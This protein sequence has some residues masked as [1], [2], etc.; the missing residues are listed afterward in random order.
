VTRSLIPH[1]S[2]LRAHPS[3]L[4]VL[5][6]CLRDSGA[7]QRHLGHETPWRAPGKAG[8]PHFSAVLPHLSSGAPL[9]RRK[10]LLK[11]LKVSSEGDFP[12]CPS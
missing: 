11:F 6:D 9:I 10:R 5:A 2:A 7:A 12:C 8:G 4:S 3:A 1:R